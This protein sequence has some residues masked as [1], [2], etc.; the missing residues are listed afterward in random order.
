MADEKHLMTSA[1]EETV[2]ALVEF[3]SE[4]DRAKAEVSA[5]MA[6]TM[7]DAMDWADA[8]KASAVSKAQEIASQKVAMA[9]AEAEAEAKK[10]RERGEVALKG[11]ED[12]I[13]RHRAKAAELAASR[14]LGESP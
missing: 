3:E 9:K 10:I 11:F 4:L 12:S 14:L 5:A 8:A 1:I 6:K 13:T 2:K 7:K